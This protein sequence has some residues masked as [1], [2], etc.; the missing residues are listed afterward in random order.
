MGNPI[1]A[2]GTLDPGQLTTFGGG[3]E[4]FYLNGIQEAGVN[5]FPKGNVENRYFTWQPRV[6]FTYDMTGNGKTVMRGGAGI[7]FERVQGNDV[8]NAALNPPFAYQPNSDK[9]AVL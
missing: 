6:G 9:R 4:K 8:Y 3:T 5:G 2:N 1:Q 7:F